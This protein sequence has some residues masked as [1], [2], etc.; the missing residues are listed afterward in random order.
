MANFDFN[1]KTFSLIQRQVFDKR[2]HRAN[3]PSFTGQN[4]AKNHE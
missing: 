1:T 2:D 3:N 4:I